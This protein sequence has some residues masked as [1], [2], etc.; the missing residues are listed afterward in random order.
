MMLAD[1]R[2]SHKPTIDLLSRPMG[3]PWIC[4]ASAMGLPWVCHMSLPWGCDAGLW[5]SH[6]HPMRLPWTSNGIILLPWVSQ[7]FIV[8]AHQSP[9]DFAWVAHVLFSTGAWV[10]HAPF[11]GLESPMWS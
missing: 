2:V 10:A 4:N 7:G 5:V 11:M 1:S 6:G 3:Y 8:L 9:M